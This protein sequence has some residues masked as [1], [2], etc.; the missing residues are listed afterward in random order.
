M[1]SIDNIM[2]AKLNNYNLAKGQLVQMQRKKAYVTECLD[3]RVISP[4]G[5]EET[6]P[7]NPFTMLLRRII[8]YMDQSIWKL[9]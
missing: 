6:S 1:T 4:K 2:K 5:I 8:L 7:S 9:C 3:Q